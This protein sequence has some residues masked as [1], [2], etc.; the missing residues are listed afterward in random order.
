MRRRLRIGRESGTCRVRTAPLPLDVGL[1]IGSDLLE[2]GARF[3][4]AD[5]D[6]GSGVAVDGTGNVIVVGDTS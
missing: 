6:E 1:A 3:G 2:G 5:D 4:G